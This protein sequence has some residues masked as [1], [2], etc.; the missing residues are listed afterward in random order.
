MISTPTLHNA[1][2]TEKHLVLVSLINW[3]IKT[4]LTGI[5]DRLFRHIKC[6]M[7]RFILRLLLNAPKRLWGQT[8]VTFADRL[9]F[10]LTDT[11]HCF[12]PCLNHYYLFVNSGVKKEAAHVAFNE[13]FVARYMMILFLRTSSSAYFLKYLH[14]WPYFQ[15]SPILMN[16][17]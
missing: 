11:L 15:K 1:L 17:C 4:S 13:W 12:M 10:F 8:S 14:L 16:Y 2:C 7:T 3:S 9:F 5:I 6:K